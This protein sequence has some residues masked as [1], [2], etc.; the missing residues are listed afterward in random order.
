MYQVKK[1]KPR[2]RFT[3]LSDS[4]AELSLPHIKDVPAEAAAAF[5]RGEEMNG[6]L[7]SCDTPEARAYIGRLGNDELDGLTD[8][9]LAHSRAE[10]ISA[11]ESDASTDS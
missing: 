11:G 3:F 7:L 5:E 1:S 9:W 4:G 10:G 8:A 2:E 6:T